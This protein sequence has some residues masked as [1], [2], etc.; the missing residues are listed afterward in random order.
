MDLLLICIALLNTGV[1]STSPEEEESIS[2]LVVQLI[3]SVPY[4][5]ER[6]DPSSLKD[7][8]RFNYP[9][10]E[11]GDDGD[12][13]VTVSLLRQRWTLPSCTTAH[14]GQFS[15]NK[16][17]TDPFAICMPAG[18]SGIVKQGRR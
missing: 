11:D 16:P 18:T 1:G 3:S 14:I 6:C 13:E 15:H 12:R 5:A 2:S 10:E 7:L 17:P 4:F 8:V 9:I